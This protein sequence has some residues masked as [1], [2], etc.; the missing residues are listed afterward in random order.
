MVSCCSYSSRELPP[1]DVINIDVEGA[2]QQV[3]SG[4]EQALRPKHPLLFVA[5]HTAALHSEC[6][7]FLK[8][9]DHK[10]EAIDGWSLGR[11]SEIVAR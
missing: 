7:Q 3:L 2:E 8:S 11:S 5:T 6:F 1:P 9:V 4:A 10:L